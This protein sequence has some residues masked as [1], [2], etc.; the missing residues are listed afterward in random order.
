MSAIS[1]YRRI[2]GVSTRRERVR[3]GAVRT[4]AIE[5][6][7]ALVAALC[8]SLLLHLLF[9]AKLYHLLVVVAMIVMATECRDVRLALNLRLPT[10]L[11]R[12]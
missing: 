5:F 12:G 1:W 4:I 6:F 3:A 7:V 8:L 2:V 11:L 10:L 9:A